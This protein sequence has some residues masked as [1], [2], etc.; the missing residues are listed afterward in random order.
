VLGAGILLVGATACSANF[1]APRSATTQGTKVLG[2]WRVL[3]VTAL[4]VGAIVVGLIAWSIVRYRRRPGGVAADFSEH[5]RLE[6]FYTVVPVVIVAVL[7]GL[8]MVVLHTVNHLSADPDLR[9]E[10]TGFQW[11]WRFNYLTQGITIVGTSNDP[12]TMVL[13]EHATA[14]LTLLSPDV[15]H[16]FYVPQFLEKRDIIPGT[17]NAIDVTPSRL[18]TF[19]GECAE[20]CG[21]DHARMLFTVQVVTPQQFQAFIAQQQQTGTVPPGDQGG[22]NQP[23]G[24]AAGQLPAGVRVG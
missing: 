8:S 13:P 15:I 18:G 4:G 2:L 24:Q 14:R 19:G 3:F 6:L 9:I 1:G 21:L 20:F 12:P 10:V 11:G 22:A 16:S 5:V 17:E 7:F 23:A